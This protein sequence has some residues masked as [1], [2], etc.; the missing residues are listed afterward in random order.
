[1][2]ELF[3]HERH[4]GNEIRVLGK[5]TLSKMSEYRATSKTRFHACFESSRW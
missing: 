3:F 4:V 5:E 1:M 2:N